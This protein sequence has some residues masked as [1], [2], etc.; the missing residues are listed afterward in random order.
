MLN[1]KF[2]IG[3]AKKLKTYGIPRPEMQAAGETVRQDAVAVRA[4]L[5]AVK[6]KIVTAHLPNSRLLGK[7]EDVTVAWWKKK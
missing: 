6:P 2:P 7:R 3:W 5:A 4:E 1:Q